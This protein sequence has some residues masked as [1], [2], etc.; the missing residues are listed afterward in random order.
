LVLGPTQPPMQWILGVLS[1]GVKWLGLETDHFYLVLR[2]I[3]G[4]V[5]PCPP[6]NS[7]CLIKIVLP[8]LIHM[9]LLVPLF[10]Y[11]ISCL[12]YISS[13]NCHVGILDGRKLVIWKYLSQFKSYLGGQMCTRWYHKALFLWIDKKGN[14][15]LR[16][17][18]KCVH[19]NV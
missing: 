4:S 16:V 18:L 11:I 19:R 7:W 2:L 1:R 13:Y 8:Y 15:N 12:S 17:P 9:S 14:L 10:L 3:C 6:S 5:P